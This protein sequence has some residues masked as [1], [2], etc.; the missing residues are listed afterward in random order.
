MSPTK[1][2]YVLAS[3]H[4][5]DDVFSEQSRGRQCTAMATA[6]AAYATIKDINLWATGDLNL[7]LLFGDLLYTN[8][9]QSFPAYQNGF[10]MIS[11]VPNEA[12]LFNTKFEVSSTNPMFGLLTDRQ[13]SE[14]AIPLDSA[15]KQTFQE[16]QT[17]ILII[18]DS[19]VMIHQTEDGRCMVFDSHARNT[20]GVPCPNGKNILMELADVEAL[21]Q[22]LFHLASSLTDC[23]APFEI[24]GM[25]VSSQPHTPGPASTPSTLTAE[26]TA[27][28]ITPE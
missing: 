5:G 15:V 14:I 13:L 4:Q 22:H 21:L 20:S 9:V 2:S 26:S 10:L 25:T 1:E 17:A 12:M 16:N 18:K 27:A 24:V 19:S 23:V 6:A 8:I 28:P 11:D 7:I 3:Y